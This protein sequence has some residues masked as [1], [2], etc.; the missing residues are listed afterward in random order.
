MVVDL[1]ISV[2]RKMVTDFLQFLA[3]LESFDCYQ[4]IVEFYSLAGHLR[5]LCVNG[6]F[7]VVCNGDEREIEAKIKEAID[8]CRKAEEFLYQGNYPPPELVDRLSILLSAI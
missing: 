5:T 2:H 6:T 8:L 7:T 1:Q 3:Q 4:G